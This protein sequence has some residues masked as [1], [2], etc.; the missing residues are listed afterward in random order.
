MREALTG[1]KNKEVLDNAILVRLLYA[2][3]DGETPDWFD[4][5]PLAQKLRGQLSPQIPPPIPAE[6]LCSIAERLVEAD[7]CRC[8]VSSGT[9]RRVFPASQ[10]LMLLG[11]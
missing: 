3:R 6:K 2:L 10:P 5:Y 9:T 8:R 4:L 7:R 11:G 1:T